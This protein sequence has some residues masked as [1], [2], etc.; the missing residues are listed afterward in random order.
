MST[1]KHA[2]SMDKLAIA[3]TVMEHLQACYNA[4]ISAAANIRAMLVSEHGDTRAQHI[5][6]QYPQDKGQ[7]IRVTCELVITENH[8][9]LFTK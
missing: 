4:R 6:K 9:E 5:M 2:A 7:E 8:M 3:E 1:T